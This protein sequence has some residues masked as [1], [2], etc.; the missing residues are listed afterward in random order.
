MINIWRLTKLQLLSSFGLNKALHTR[1]VKERRKLLLLSIG[2]LIG[3]AMIAAVSFGYSYMMA[4]SFEQIG[5]IDLLLAI[6]MVATSIIGFFTTIYKASGVL[7]NFKDYDL[8]MSLPI[9]TSHVVASRVLQLYILNLFFTLMVMVP[10]GAVYAIR[11]NP[12]ALYFLFYL[13]TLFVIP[14]LPIIAATI[15]GSLISWISSRFRAS[16]IISIILTFAFI[17][18]FMVVSMRMDGNEQVLADMGAQ[19]ADMIFK[20]YPFAA[21]YVEAVCSYQVVPLLLFIV[22][23][24]L[25]FMLFVTVLGTRYKAIHTGLTTSHASGKYVIKHLNTS[26]PFRALYMKE[27]RR[28]FSSSLY[29]LNTSIGMVLLLVMS[30]SL[31]FIGSGELGELMEIPQLSEYLNKLAPLVVSM[32]V[33]IS[34]TTS[35]SISLEGNNLWILKSSPVPKSTILLSKVAVNLTI[36]LPILIISSVM[37]MISLGTGWIESMLLLVIPLIFACFSAIMGVLVNLK[38]PKLEWTSEVAV[39]KQSA[40]VLVSMLISFI[41]LVICIGLALLLSNVNGD[42]VLLSIGLLMAV[43]CIVLYR[44]IQTK[45]EQ[46]FQAL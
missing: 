39:I 37:L 20:L 34:C 22:T 27:L 42:L 6:M 38:L 28:Y 9:K 2:I 35:S 14:L 16:R 33:A 46:L 13:I 24:V 25:A 5:R 18:G 29:V 21:L 19:L 40:S 4:L 3:V 30:I 17:I 31:L 1:D 32:F 36:T 26:S 45:G 41:T 7:F 23:S 8:V 11:V 15:I 10:A 12:E 44:Y 43:V